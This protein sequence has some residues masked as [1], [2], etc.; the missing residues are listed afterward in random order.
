M[1]LPTTMY[2]YVS[3]GTM[4]ILLTVVVTCIIAAA[5]HVEHT[6]RRCY[7]YE[8]QAS[9]PYAIG[10]PEGKDMVMFMDVYVSRRIECNE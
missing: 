10:G 9:Y 4:L 5:L 6:E 3:F 2:E 7:W 8:K 1:K